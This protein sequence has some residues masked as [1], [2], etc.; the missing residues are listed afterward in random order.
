[1]C[2]DGL[3]TLHFVSQIS[4][5][6]ALANLIRAAAHQYTSL[7]VANSGNRS[8]ARDKLVVIEVGPGKKIYHVHK[9]LL[10]HH[11]EYFQKSLNGPWKEGTEQ[12]VT[13]TDIEALTFEIILQW[14]YTTKLPSDYHNMRM[15][16]LESSTGYHL[17]DDDEYA[18]A[19]VKA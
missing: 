7:S 12:K 10:T 1:M 17:V 6:T 9:A 13:L 16:R 15:L 2:Q 5:P 8:T 18:S 4:D 3:G 19:M 11:S 14:V